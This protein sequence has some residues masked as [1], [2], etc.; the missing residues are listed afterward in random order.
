[1]R[2]EDIFL[3]AEVQQSLPARLDFL[4]NY[5]QHVCLYC[6]YKVQGFRGT[7]ARV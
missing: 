3:K 6:N 5:M 1:M 4:L 7:P 2:D